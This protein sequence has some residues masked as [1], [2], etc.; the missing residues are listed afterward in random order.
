MN[1]VFILN[2]QGVLSAP[3]TAFIRFVMRLF[4][5]KFKV[6][7]EIPERRF[8][9][10]RATN[11]ERVRRLR[12]FLPAMVLAFSLSAIAFILTAQNASALDEHNCLSC[13]G[14]SDVVK[15]TGDGTQISLRVLA[16]D[17]NN[18]AHRFIDCTACHSTNPHDPNMNISKLGS[19]E[20]CGTCH[21][22]EY[23]QHLSSIH[24]QQLAQGNADVATCVDCHSTK[25]DPHSVMRVLDSNA[26][27]YKKNIADTCAKCHNNQDLMNSYGIVDKVYESYMRSYH[28]KVIEM[29]SSEL[30][31]LNT[32]TCTNCHGAHNIRAINDPTSPVV[33]MDNLVQTCVQC[34]PNAG[35]EFVKGFLGHK[36]A[37]A[38]TIP[39]AHYVE[40]S[41]GFLLYGVMGFAVLVVLIAVSSYSRKRW[42]S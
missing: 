32:A 29:S 31:Q 4:S 23:K 5:L 6:I 19:A 2:K 27:T 38:T 15:T 22:Y 3:Y 25:S 14:K 26:S 17:I 33:G 24:G 37:S 36:E 40:R 21:Q 42:R 8:E 9:V 10:N 28:G 16:S 30:S 11:S 18:S 35:T 41:F 34:H 1:T 7:N 39:V 12:L 20:K 13:H